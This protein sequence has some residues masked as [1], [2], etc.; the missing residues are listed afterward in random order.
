MESS[1]NVY[2]YIGKWNEF[3]VTLGKYT[4]LMML[5]SFL[6]GLI[7]GIWITKTYICNE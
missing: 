7:L 5:L 2:I 1:D 4:I 3:L 6:I